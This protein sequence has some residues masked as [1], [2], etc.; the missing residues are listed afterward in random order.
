M[1]RLVTFLL[2]LA[3]L[4]IIIGAL[5]KGARA[6]SF[7]VGLLALILMIGI[8]GSANSNFFSNLF[9]PNAATDPATTEAQSFDASAQQSG[10]TTPD[11]A[12]EGNAETSS[13]AATGTRSTTGTATGR[14]GTTTTTTGPNGTRTTTTS[15][16]TRPGRRALW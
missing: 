1:N 7:F 13:D 15:T 5:N 10:D 16:T 4:S 2:V 12:V 6:I 14:N 9:N 8:P 3:I 11:E